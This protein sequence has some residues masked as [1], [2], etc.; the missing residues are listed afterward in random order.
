M[1]WKLKKRIIQTY[2]SQINFA[3][4]IKVSESI[5]SKVIRGRRQLDSETQNAWAKALAC[6]PRDIFADE[7]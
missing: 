5:V 2:G 7:S 1:N 4:G 6:K 3:Q